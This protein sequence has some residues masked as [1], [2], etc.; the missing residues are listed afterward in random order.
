MAES[1][2]T[3]SRS[4]QGGKSAI[5]QGTSVS[6]SAIEEEQGRLEQ[7]FESGR[8]SMFQLSLKLQKYRLA[9]AYQEIRHSNRCVEFAACD[10]SLPTTPFFSDRQ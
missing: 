6:Q 1:S 3:G 2:L 7:S 5:R 9:E 8:E 4:E 10:G